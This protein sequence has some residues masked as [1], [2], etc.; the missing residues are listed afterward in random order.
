MQNSD[1][2]EVSRMPKFILIILCVQLLVVLFLYKEVID[3]TFFCILTPI[4]L[5]LLLLR[6]KIHLHPEYLEYQ[7]F[8][9]HFKKKRIYWNEVAT[10]QIVKIDPITDFWG[11]GLRYSKKYGISYVLGNDHGLFVVLK[12][13]KRRTFTIKNKESIKSFLDKNN[14]NH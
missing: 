6:L 12:N 10:V 1:V 8:P 2:V 11:W 4:I 13:E 5:L 7:F 9:F 14:I 3:I